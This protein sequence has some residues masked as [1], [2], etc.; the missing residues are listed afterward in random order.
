MQSIKAF[1]KCLLCFQSNNYLLIHKIQV[2][3]TAN[4]A[5]KR[6]LNSWLFDTQLKPFTSCGEYERYDSKVSPNGLAI[7]CLSTK[8]SAKT[9]PKTPQTN[10]LTEE[11]ISDERKGSDVKIAGIVGI[12][13]WDMKKRV[14]VKEWISV[15][16][17]PYIAHLRTVQRLKILLTIMCGVLIPVSYTLY[18]FDMRSL[19]AC[20]VSTAL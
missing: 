15:F 20:H 19:E 4:T 16:H 10:P 6:C 12:H 14:R 11:S 5:H 17:F 7:R 18:A 3:M 8:E 1:N 13:Q 2:N 9:D